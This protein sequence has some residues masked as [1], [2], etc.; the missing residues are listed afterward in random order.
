MLSAMKQKKDQGYS[1]WKLNYI[2]EKIHNCKQETNYFKTSL[3]DK[4][5]LGKWSSGVSSE[6]SAR[7]M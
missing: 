5:T 2:L 6:N 1:K 7:S 3:N 4:H